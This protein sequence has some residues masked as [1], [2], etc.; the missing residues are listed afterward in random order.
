MDILTKFSDF[1]D[2]KVRNENFTFFNYLSL[3]TTPLQLY[4]AGKVFFPEL[5]FDGNCIFIKDSPQYQYLDD[6]KNSNMSDN[7]IEKYIN[8]VMLE[9]LFAEY[10]EY[11]ENFYEELAEMI[12]NSWELHFEKAYPNIKM[13]VEKYEDEFDGWCVTCYKKR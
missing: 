7:A 3:K 13:T 12:K 4:L 9:C 6:C 5:I 11:N 8:S 2:W 10:S 1:N